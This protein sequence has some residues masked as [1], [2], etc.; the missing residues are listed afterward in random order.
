MASPTKIPSFV[1]K[2]NTHKQNSSLPTRP[3]ERQSMYSQNT[4]E[5]M[6]GITK[7][8]PGR[9]REKVVKIS[10]RFRE[11]RKTGGEKELWW[12]RE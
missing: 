11:R 4:I 12:E 10:W 5:K 3:Q 8:A 6:R 2:R 7:Q 9:E 1:E